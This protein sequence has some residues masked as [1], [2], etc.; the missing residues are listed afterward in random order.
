MNTRNSVCDKSFVMLS[1]GNFEIDRH[2]IRKI[3]SF[4]SI[5]YSAENDNS[6]IKNFLLCLTFQS[7]GKT[8][9]FHD[10]NCMKRRKYSTW[11]CPANIFREFQV[12]AIA[13]N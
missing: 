4:V 3:P 12:I 1:S 9:G 10:E 6:V 8:S 13:K 2:V 11:N 5:I 7:F